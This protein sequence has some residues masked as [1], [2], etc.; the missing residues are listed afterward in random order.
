MTERRKPCAE[1][2]DG[3][4]DTQSPDRQQA[5]D[6]AIDVLHDQALRDFQLETYRRIRTDTDRLLDLGNKTSNAQM[7]R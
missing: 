4:G 7:E 6:T 3:N 1:I 2:V 5:D